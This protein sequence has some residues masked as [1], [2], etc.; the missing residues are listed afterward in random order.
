MFQQASLGRHCT[1]PRSA[2]RQCQALRTHSVIVVASAVDTGPSTSAPREYIIRRATQA[3]S[4]SIAAVCGESFGRGNFPELDVEALHRLEERYAAVI[5][6]DMQAKL[7]NAL[8]AKAQAQ[9]EHRE[10]RLRQ[11]M[12]QL[13]AELA[14][15]RGEPARFVTQLSPQDA[16]MVQRWRRSRQFLILVAVERN[17]QP[18]PTASMVMASTAATRGTTCGGGVAVEVPEALLPPPF[19]SSKPFRLYVSNMSVL[20]SHRRR[21]LARRL[22]QQCERVARLWGH[23]SLWLHVKQNNFGAEALYQSMGYRRVEE[24][25]LR[26]LPGPLAHVLMCKE[27]PPLRHRCSVALG[28]S[29]A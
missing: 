29:A 4:R 15:L 11:Y 9:R 6:E 7:V 25:G 5:E 24:G 3:D 27:L 2:S 18:S 10:F 13:R 21:G 16:R 22:L 19:P 28:Q 14:A 8:E 20:P 1:A 12:Q 26:L 23:S 17:P